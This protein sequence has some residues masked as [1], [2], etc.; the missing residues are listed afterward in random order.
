LEGLNSES[1]FLDEI[2][3]KVLRGFFLGLALHNHLYS[4]LLRFLFLQT[5]R[6]LLQFQ[7]WERWRLW[8]E[9]SLKLYMHEFG[10]RFILCSWLSHH[11]AGILTHVFFSTSTVSIRVLRMRSVEKTGGSMHWWNILKAKS[12]KGGAH[13]R[14]PAYNSAFSRRPT[15]NTWWT[16]GGPVHKSASVLLNR[17][18]NTLINKS[19][20]SSR[21]KVDRANRRQLVNWDEIA[22]FV[23][24]RQDQNGGLWLAT[25][26]PCRNLP[27]VDE[28]ILQAAAP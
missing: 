1:E 11:N 15:H 9:N 21:L 19:P 26:V 5:H 13:F 28:R 17:V 8:E 3:T 22:G 4:F 7:V 20:K 25:F 12:W 2:Q 6:N 10:F 24:F 27:S 14:C 18:K 23:V 16:I